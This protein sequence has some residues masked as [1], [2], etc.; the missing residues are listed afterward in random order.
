MDYWITSA[1]E[2]NVALNAIA[3]YTFPH[4]IGRFQGLGTGSLYENNIDSPLEII[5]DEI[6]YNRNKTWDFKL[7]HS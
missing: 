3:Q 5:G 7:L 1:L 4:A 2:S 6:Q